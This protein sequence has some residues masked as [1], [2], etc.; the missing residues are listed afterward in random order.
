MFNNGN[1]EITL[2]YNSDKSDDKKARGYLESI[3][4]YCIKTFDL[5]KERITETQ[6]AQLAEKMNAA[7]EDLID[8]TYDDHIGVHREGLKLIEREQM[9]T[10]MRNDPKLIRTPLL[11]IGK[12]VF[13]FGTGYDFI[14]ADMVRDVSGI[15][16]AN[17]EEQR[18]VDSKR[19]HGY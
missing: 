13:K 8:P 3:Q 12:K 10:L 5:A 15:K 7:I 2:I 1:R 9:L 11:V 19:T 14:K 6:L 18:G 16:S 4:G 17:R